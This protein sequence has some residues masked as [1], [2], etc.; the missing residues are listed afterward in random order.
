MYNL[1]LLLALFCMAE[2]TTPPPQ[3]P[4]VQV[5]PGAFTMGR[6]DTGLDAAGG[7]D[8]LPR[9]E[10][11][12]D[13]YAI[14]QHEVTNAAFA[15]VYNWAIS[16]GK[17]QAT[18]IEPSGIRKGDKPLL[19]LRT[20]QSMLRVEQGQLMTQPLAGQPPEEFPV[21]FV[22][23]YGA[24]AFCQWLSEWQGLPGCYD[25]ERWECVARDS[26]GYRLPSEAEWERAAGWDSTQGAHLIHA[27]TAEPSDRVMN[28]YDSARTIYANPARLGVMPFVNPAG[29]FDGTRAERVA[30][31]AGCQDMSGNLWEWCGDW[32]AADYYAQSPARN[33]AGPDT[34]TQRVERG[35]SWRSPAQHCRTAKRNYDSPT[36]A[37]WDLG[38]RVARSI[39]EASPGTTAGVWT[40][41][42]K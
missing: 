23:W 5:P 17:V 21:T 1:S 29:W 22:T 27:F 14:G 9:H 25:L 13:A 36:L 40:P 16:Q 10:V 2:A 32:Y 7:D 12:L 26:G 42:P 33:P 3:L 24:V 19:D 11:W 37:T 8:E 31:P 38:F 6:L 4:M 35:G 34:G 18:E 41:A 20:Q 28:F 15:A 30:S 39:K